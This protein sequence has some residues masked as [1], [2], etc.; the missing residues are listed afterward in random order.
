MSTITLTQTDSPSRSKM[1]GPCWIAIDG[2]YATESGRNIEAEVGK[3]LT[4]AGKVNLRR[5]TK[6]DTKRGSWT[7]VVTGDE[8][9]TVTV[10]LGSPQAVEAT[11]TGVR[12]A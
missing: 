8:A 3:T 4:V 11:I 1:A 9:D 10:R 2:T 12:E 7:V 5:S 6:T